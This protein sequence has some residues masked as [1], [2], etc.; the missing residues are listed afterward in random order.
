MSSD[1]NFVFLEHRGSGE[2]LVYKS[3]DPITLRD[4]YDFI[5][6]IEYRRKGVTDV[7]KEI[8][9]LPNTYSNCVADNEYYSDIEYTVI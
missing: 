7:I 3:S 5:V 8:L 2:D 1:N 4:K 6:S 9:P